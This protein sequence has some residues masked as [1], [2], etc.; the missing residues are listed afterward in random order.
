MKKYDLVHVSAS[1]KRNGIKNVLTQEQVNYI[2][3][4]KDKKQESR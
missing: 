4:N 1:R 2:L 3:D